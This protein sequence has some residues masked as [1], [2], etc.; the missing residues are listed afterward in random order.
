MKKN[1]PA[2]SPSCSLCG[3]DNMPVIQCE[4]GFICAECSEKGILGR[5]TTTRAA[6]ALQNSLRGQADIA[7]KKS[8]NLV[9]DELREYGIASSEILA[10]DALKPGTPVE[11]MLGGEVLPSHDPHFMDTLAVPGVSAL[12][13]S[14]NRLE[15]LTMLGTDVAAMGMDAADSIQATNSMEK[16]LAHQLAVCHDAAMRYVRKASVE[17]DPHNASLMMNLALRSMGTFQ[18]GLLTMKS[19]RGTGQQCITVQHVTVEGGGQAVIGNIK[20]EGGGSK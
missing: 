1:L 14:A 4:G 10:Q 18:K 2:R 20:T 3:Q 6:R 15:L 11:L 19:L 5:D 7:R 12:D 8:K 16:M 17:Q 13:A 9:V